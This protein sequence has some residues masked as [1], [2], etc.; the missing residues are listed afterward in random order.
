[1][2]SNRLVRRFSLTCLGSLALPL[3]ASAST[4]DLG[5]AVETALKVMKK[6][7]KLLPVAKQTALAAQAPATQTPATQTP[8]PAQDSNGRALPSPLSSPPFPGSDWLGTFVIGEPDS[9]PTYPLQKALF[10]NS[11]DKSH[12]K[13]YGYVDASYNYS[14]SKHNNFPMTYDIVANHPE[15]DQLVVRVERPLDTVQTDHMDY[16]FRFSGLYGTDYRFTIGKGYL[17]DQLL[18]R[19]ALYGF[20]PVEMYGLIYVPKVYQ[21]MVIQ[22]GR[23]ISPPDIEAQLAPQNYLFSHS[24]MFTVDPYTFTGVNATIRLSPYWQILFGA[25]G[26]NDMAPWE[27]S[28]QL[29]GELLARWV[30]HDN[31]D[32]IWGGINSLGAGKFR[33]EH[34]NLQHFVA[35]WQHKFSE[36]YHMMTEGYYE[37]EYDADQ[38]GTVVDGPVEPYAGAG[39]GKRLPGRSDA[40]GLVN[41]FQILTSQKDYVSIRNDYLNDPRGFRTG[42]GTAYESWTVGYVRYLTPTIF[43][44]PE[45]RYEHAYG[46][47][48][49]DNGTRRD[50]WSIAADIIMKF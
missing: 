29:N 41:Y 21:G 12:I 4:V 5:P 10:G 37:F 39:A 47:T 11:L 22:Y 31:N 49:Y 17:S 19:N 43:V 45:V 35:T 16:G 42:F 27:K 8:A 2:K 48:P 33:D 46:A 36:K 38:G 44:R 1:M 3:A 28:S 18:K 50:Q 34:D 14:T 40:T 30:S 7:G 20:D 6:E 25:H 13:I 23:Y 15:L 32:S 24:L 9:T 26:G